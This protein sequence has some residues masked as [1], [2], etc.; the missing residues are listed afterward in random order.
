VDFPTSSH[1]HGW[2]GTG[3]ALFLIVACTAAVIKMTRTLIPWQVFAIGVAVLIGL[4]AL[5]IILYWVVTLLTGRYQLDRNG[6][7]ILWGASR[8]WVPIGAIQDIV[9]A[10]DLDVSVL[11]DGAATGVAWLGGTSGRVRLQNGK[12][13]YLRTTEPLDHSIAILTDGNVYVISPAEPDSFLEAL[14]VRRPLGPTQ[15]W[16][17]KE[18]KTW[19]PGLPI[20][21]DALAWGLVGGALVTHLV[22][23]GYLAFVYDRLPQALSFHF[24]TLGQPDRIGD[25][26]EIVRLPLVAFLMLAF[27]LALGFAV[28]R[29]HRIA[30]YLIWGGG[31]IL[32]LLTW[33]ALF[34]ITG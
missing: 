1:R 32:Q 8:L 6:V 25:R 10:A 27:D 13:V 23:D 18:Q 29:R 31:L 4:I 11:P 9:P 17:E 21:R 20:W 30:A 28:Y 15:Q 14:R 2:I 22:V 19:L 16:R 33:G 26:A 3:I 24:N 5:A 7:K 34:T 12:N